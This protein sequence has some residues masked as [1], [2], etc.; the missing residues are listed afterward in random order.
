MLLHLG[1]PELACCYINVS[2]YHRVP[3]DDHDDLPCPP[4]KK[5]SRYSKDEED[6]VR[7]YFSVVERTTPAKLSECTQFLREKQGGADNMFVGRTSQQIQDK[8]KTMLRQKHK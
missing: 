5:R 6:L 3:D 1:H 8:I 7:E 2:L 4:R